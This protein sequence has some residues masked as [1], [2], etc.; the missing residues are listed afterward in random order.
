ML[1]LGRMLLGPGP[2][3]RRRIAVSLFGGGIASVGIDP[4]LADIDDEALRSELIS[5]GQFLLKA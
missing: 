3:A 5:L 2:N 1:Q 4:A